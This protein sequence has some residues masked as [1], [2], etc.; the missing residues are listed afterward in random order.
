MDAERDCEGKARKGRRKVGI[1]ELL[2]VDEGSEALNERM[3]SRGGMVDV[4]IRETG[5]SRGESE[6]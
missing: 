3:Q 4:L 5:A 1:E 2:E 6:K